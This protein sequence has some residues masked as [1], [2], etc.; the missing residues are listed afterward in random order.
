MHNYNVG[1]STMVA[2]SRSQAVGETNG[3]VKILSCAT[4]DRVLG[5]H[6]IN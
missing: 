6:I 1:K 3:M 5:V 4:T 2:N